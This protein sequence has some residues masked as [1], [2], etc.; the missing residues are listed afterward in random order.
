ME[1][2][3]P[4]TGI[5]GIVTFTHG[6]GPNSARSSQFGNFFKEINMRVEEER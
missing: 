6:F 1:S 2:H 5:L 3:P 4:G